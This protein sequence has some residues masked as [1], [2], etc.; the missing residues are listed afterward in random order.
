MKRFSACC[1]GL[2]EKVHSLICA[3]ET[4]PTDLANSNSNSNSQQ[5]TANHSL[6]LIWFLLLEP[7]SVNGFSFDARTVFFSN[8]EREKISICLFQLER[9][10][11]TEYEIIFFVARSLEKCPKTSEKSHVLSE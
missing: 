2:R 5:P 6:L 10:T 9:K 11:F 4:E 7:P 1:S 8:F 3:G